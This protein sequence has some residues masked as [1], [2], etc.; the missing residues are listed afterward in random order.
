MK[1]GVFL[2]QR[3]LGRNTKELLEF[4]TAAD[5]AGLSFLQATD[6]VLGAD[7]AAY[8]GQVFPYDIHDFLHEQ[9]VLFAYLAGVTRL[10]F[11]NGVLVLP[12]RQ[13]ALVAKQAAEVDIL[14]GGRLRLGVGTGWNAIEYAA[15]NAPFEDRG[16]RFEEQ[17]HVLRKL[18]TEE[19]V[20]FEGQFHQLHGVGILPRPARPIPIWIGG[21]AGPS[22]KVLD[23]IGRLA[24]G[25][26]ASRPATEELASKLKI[27]HEAARAAGRDQLPELNLGTRINHRNADILRREIDAASALNAT[28]FTIRA[29][30]PSD[31]ED[32]RRRRSLSWYLDMLHFAA[33]VFREYQREDT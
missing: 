3:E 17:I 2:P 7:P 23:R 25:W 28:Y 19:A 15:L 29:D 12:Q 30:R 18:W 1:F 22:R 9:F 4:I 26:L 27:V 33:D 8:S 5:E 6:H 10:D 32:K 31:P 11:V 14:S 16:A 24:D 20:T 21:G 13:T